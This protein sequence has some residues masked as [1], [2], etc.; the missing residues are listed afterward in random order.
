ME[1]D[2][3]INLPPFYA[4]QQVV[5]IGPPTGKTILNRGEVY[6][7]ANCVYLVSS[8]PI[9]ILRESFWYV[10]IVGYLNG[11]CCLAHY[12]FVPVIQKD[13]PAMTFSEIVEVEELQILLSN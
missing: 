5:F 13:F 1:R 10:G 2:G 9:N 6:T 4:G 8:N 7:I 11:L 3:K 12:I